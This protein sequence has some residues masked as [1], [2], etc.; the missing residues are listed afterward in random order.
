MSDSHSSEFGISGADADDAG[1][2]HCTFCLDENTYASDTLSSPSLSLFQGP[3]LLVHNNAVFT[4]RDFASISQI[5]DSLKRKDEG[6]TGRFGIGFN[7]V[8]HV[9]DL[10]TFVS[11]THLVMFDPHC[12]F[13]PNVSHAN[14]GKRVDF[15]ESELAVKNPDQVAP[16]CHLGCDMRSAFAG[17]LFRLP[18][19]TPHFATA[20]KSKLSEQVCFVHAFQ[21]WKR[22]PCNRLC[23]RF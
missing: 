20:F 8:Y 22:T 10:P 11:G 12:N 23:H 18:L 14:P 4:E 16:F 1:A 9:T 7:S 17:T 2:S 5:G 21:L 6:K 19:R 13:I 15:I 3:S